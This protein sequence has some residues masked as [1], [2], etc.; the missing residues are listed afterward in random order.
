MTL[1]KYNQK[2]NFSKTPEPVGNATKKSKFLYIIQKHAAS[3]LHYDFRLELDGVLKSWA[4]PKGPSLDPT[5]KRLAVHV[6]DHPVEYGSFE[7]TIPKGQYGGGTVMLWDKGTWLPLD[8]DVRKAYKKGHLTFELKGQKLQGKWML[9][10]IK[11]DPKNWLLMKVNDDKAK[12]EA[13]KNITDIEMLSVKSGKSMDEIANNTKSKIWQSDKSKDKVIHHKKIAKQLMPQ[14]ISPE[15]ATLVD[16]AP[17]GNKWLHEIKYDGYRLITYIKNNKVRMMT[18]GGLD[19][20]NKFLTIKHALEKMSLPNVIFDG[21]VIAFDKKGQSNFQLLQ[22]ALQSKKT[23]KL[24]YFIFDI[25]YY[26]NAVLF[27]M[28]L[29]ARK[30]ILQALLSKQNKIIFYSDHIVGNGP[31]VFTKACKSNLEGIISKKVDSAYRQVRTQD[32]VKVKCVSRQEFVI[33][34]YTK[35]A[36]NRRHFGALLVGVY[37]KDKNL[38]YSG[39]VGTGFNAETLKEIGNQLKEIATDTNPFS[40]KPPGGKNITWVK[41]QF[42]AE[43]EY[44]EMTHE[45]MLRHPSFKGLRK[46]KAPKKVILEKPKQTERII[47]AKTKKSNKR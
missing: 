22:N 12:S 23:T 8:E 10:Q 40:S 31:K 29:I 1:K 44:T 2:R 38:V 42:L 27:D 6:E 18:R 3:H 21:E 28:P 33:G 5:V 14:K 19:W 32:W 9:V 13:K 47:H 17:S 36:G 20:T 30:E 45:G 35:P 25:L 39:R 4:V 26:D 37:N 41:P 15:L 43:V 11:K 7:G 16:A 34:G 24:G 46:D